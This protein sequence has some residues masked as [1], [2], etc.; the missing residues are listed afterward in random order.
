M[1]A[2][3]VFKVRLCNLRSVKFVLE[4]SVLIGWFGTIELTTE[5]KV[6]QEAGE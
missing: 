6:A 1:R 3:A 4:L 5:A 2:T